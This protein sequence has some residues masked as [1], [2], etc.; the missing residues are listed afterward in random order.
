MIPNGCAFY[1][2]KSLEKVRG[3]GC[4]YKAVGRNR[5]GMIWVIIILAVI[6]S[7][8]LFIAGAVAWLLVRR[9]LVGF[10]RERSA[11]PD[12]YPLKQ[13]PSRFRR[14]IVNI[15]DDWFFH[16]NGLRLDMIRTAI[17]NNKSARRV[18]MGGSTITQQLIKNIYFRFTHNYL[19]KLLEAIMALYAEKVLTKEQILEL[20]LNIIY[21]GNGQYGIVDAA[22]YYF[23]KR[24]EE[25]T[26]NQ[27]FLMAVMPYAPTTANPIKHTDVFIRVRDRRLKF[28]YGRKIISRQ[29]MRRIQYYDDKYPDPDMRPCGEA[30]R[31]YSDTIVLIN[32]RFG[33]ERKKWKAK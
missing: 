25:L 32:E 22:R 2:G 14:Y 1:E 33:P 13:L 26:M 3:F 16:H 9:P 8:P 12:Y 15:E 6:F 31:N 18:I 19:R 27:Q 29:D 24:P 17:N 10:Y 5:V 23:D 30:E 4:G 28:L 20:Y 11:E 21:F 7:V